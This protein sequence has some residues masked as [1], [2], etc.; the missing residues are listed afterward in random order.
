[1]HVTIELE[2]SEGLKVVVFNHT[3]ESLEEIDNLVRII[4]D[5]FFLEGGIHNY[6][7]SLVEKEKASKK[8]E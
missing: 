2:N 7:E 6:I 3:V 8:T 4:R 5:T 1:M